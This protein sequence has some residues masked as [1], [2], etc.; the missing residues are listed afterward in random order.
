MIAVDVDPL[1]DRAPLFS[2]PSYVSLSNLEILLWCIEA[3]TFSM[4]MC[5][6]HLRLF[7][8]NDR[9][10]EHQRFIPQFC[11]LPISVSS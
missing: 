7:Y 2:R 11:N 6:S 5:V 9:Q 4:P 3:H 10:C 1:P 8:C